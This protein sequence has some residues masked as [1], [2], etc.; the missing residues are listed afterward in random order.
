M[1]LKTILNDRRLRVE[2]ALALMLPA[3]AGLL[4]NHFEAM[5]YSLFAG[6]KRI[7]PVLCMLAAEL[8]GADL[9]H[10]MAVP[11][12][13]EC[14][15]TYSLIHD[16]LPAMD[17]DDLRRGKP[18]NHKIYGEAQAILAGDGLLTLAFELLTRPELTARLSAV[19][20]L[21]IIRLTAQAAGARG[22]VGG[23]SL[24]VAAEGQEVPFETLRT[25]H[26]CKT[27]ALI[28][29]SVQVG[30][31]IGHASESQFDALTEYGR[32]LG[33]AFQIT[34][35]LLN[36]EGNPEDLGKAAGSDAERLK[37]TYPA[38]FGIEGTRQKATEAVEAAVTSLNI[39]DDRAAPLQQLARYVLKRNK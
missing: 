2:E 37:A 36:V 5:R 17:N 30:A 27:G 21:R 4:A 35:D 15:H 25:I 39:F 9:N 3:E 18:T 19:E 33:L 20:Q 24:D 10:M 7:R 29:A 28:T 16:D 26:R 31:V 13:L 12:A 6:G 14:I 38:Y 1:E 23:Q 32:H 8:L 34:D 11:C 22:M